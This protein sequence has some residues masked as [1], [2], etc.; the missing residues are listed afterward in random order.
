M[1]PATPGPFGHTPPLRQ[2]ALIKS[3]S[4]YRSSTSSF[5]KTAALA[6]P[7][8]DWKAIWCLLACSMC[9]CELAGRLMELTRMPY[10]YSHWQISSS[11][12]PPAN[13]ILPQAGCSFLQSLREHQPITEHIPVLPLY[14]RGSHRS[15]GFIELSSGVTLNCWLRLP[16]I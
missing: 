15:W 6:L 4:R 3:S 7:T 10:W 8:A 16:L 1:H 14:T 5:W 12:L 2:I 9:Y 11:S 13:H